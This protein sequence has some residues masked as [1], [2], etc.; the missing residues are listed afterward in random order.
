[1]YVCIFFAVFFFSILFL[2]FFTFYVLVEMALPKSKKEKDALRK[3]RLRERREQMLVVREKASLWKGNEGSSRGSS[4]G[5]SKEMGSSSFSGVHSALLNGN[6]GS[7]T[8]VKEEEEESGMK[9]EEWEEGE[10]GE[11]SLS[12]LSSLLSN[13][14][15]RTPGVASSSVASSSSFASSMTPSV[16]RLREGVGKALREG[17]WTGSSGG[18]HENAEEEEAQKDDE[19]HRGGY[20]I[21]EKGEEGE[22]EAESYVLEPLCE[23]AA[24]LLGEVWTPQGG[25]ATTRS[26]TEAE[27]EEGRG[28]DSGRPKVGGGEGVG[29]D[30][31]AIVN[32]EDP[33]KVILPKLFSSSSLSG[34]SREQNGNRSGSGAQKKDLRKGK[35]SRK[36]TKIS[37][38]KLKLAVLQRFGSDGLDVVES[39]DGNTTDPLFTVAMKV[40]HRGSVAVPRH[41]DRLHPFLSNQADREKAAVVPLRVQRLGVAQL[42]ASKEKKKH[43]EVDHIAFMSC[44]LTGSP[45]QHHGFG[46]DQPPYLCST[47]GDVFYEGKWMPPPALAGTGTGEGGQLLPGELSSTLRDALGLRDRHSPPPW[48][49]A[50]QKLRRLPPAYP[51]LWIP[52]LNAPIPLGAQWGK[53]VG[54]WGEP[55]RGADQNFL[56]PGV[57]DEALATASASSNTTTTTT[58]TAAASS[59]RGAWKP[60]PHTHAYHQKT[61]VWG[62][63]PALVPPT[64]EERA[65]A[66]EEEEEL[67]KN[68]RKRSKRE[69]EEEEGSSSSTAAGGSRTRG[70]TGAALPAITPTPFLPKTFAQAHPNWNATGG[71]NASLASSSSLGGRSGDGLPR[72]GPVEK[73]Y[74][75]VLSNM[76]GDAQD[77]TGGPSR[78]TIA[79]GSTLVPKS[80]AASPPPQPPGKQSTM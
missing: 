49:Y 44:F 68:K 80:H 50:M 54:Q 61:G 29:T 58:S 14:V 2:I 70:M 36:H 34:D 3:E 40:Q 60:I 19:M 55:P 39:S 8:S 56:F 79:V 45:L 17:R 33:D 71:S 66:E 76:V 15:P 65:L 47:V 38:E 72:S 53:G 48:L 77:G 22:A 74:V 41:W 64:A 1:M 78:S 10:T 21:N 26:G 52:G 16:S 18:V 69:G 27:E 43:Q 20:P 5:S 73:E 37:W 75:H 24:K 63:V 62:C 12:D 59:S 46:M 28:W 42:R 32:R 51:D 67:Q 31:E 7:V 30:T 35:L 13:L 6:F 25:E 9:K 23:G 11:A 4:S 57:M